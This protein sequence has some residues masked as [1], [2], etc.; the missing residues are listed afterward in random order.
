MMEKGQAFKV[1]RI[2]LAPRTRTVSYSVA[3]IVE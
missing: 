3:P 1:S 2:L